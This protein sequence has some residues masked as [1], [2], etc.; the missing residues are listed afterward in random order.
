L[1]NEIN[2]HFDSYLVIRVRRLDYH[3]FDFTLKLMM[4]QKWSM[5]FWVT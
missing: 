4:R 3:E 2:N 5:I 1:V